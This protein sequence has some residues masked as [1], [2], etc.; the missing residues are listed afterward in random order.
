LWCAPKA[1]GAA[2]IAI[3]K[4]LLAHQSHWAVR[5]IIHFMKRT[6]KR[7]D[8]TSRTFFAFIE[9][10]SAFSGSLYRARLG[11]RPLVHVPR[12]QRGERDRAVA[13]ELR[14]ADDEQ[15]A[16]A[17][18][19]RFLDDA[20]KIASLAALDAP[21]NAADA[22]EAGLV[23]FAPDEIDWDDEVRQAVEARR[24]SRRMP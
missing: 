17:L 6:L 13:D 3:D 1:T 11:R 19:T 18:Q 10:G 20:D 24:R 23:T 21:L 5:E 15:R 14:S 22:E 12:R 7:V 2:V 16:D 8:L 9:T 4:T